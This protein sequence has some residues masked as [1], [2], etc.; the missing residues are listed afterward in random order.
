M[1]GPLARLNLNADKLHP[2]AG[3]LL[4]QL[5]DAVGKPLPW[6]SNSLS[7]LARGLEV[8][9]ALALA[10]DLLDAYRPPARPFV[11]VT[12]REG[13]GRHGTEAPRGLCWHAYRTDPD[14]SIAE[15]RIVPPTSQNQTS[16]EEDLRDVAAE[17][18]ELDDETATLRC[19]QVIR[20]YDP[21]ISCSVH[22]LKLKRETE[23]VVL[24]APTP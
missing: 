19:E 12:P 5:C 8:V 24:G 3:E 20:H 15:A 22:F 6:R 11:P 10:A 2:Q 7:L 23:D 17:I 13:E 18:L 9:H 16:I 1:V 4:P 21:C 14:G